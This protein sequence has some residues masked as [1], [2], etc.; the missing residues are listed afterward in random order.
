MELTHS[1][2]SDVDEVASFVAVFAKRSQDKSK[3]SQDDEKYILESNFTKNKNHLFFVLLLKGIVLYF[4]KYTYSLVVSC[5]P[6]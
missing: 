4:G 6:C 5:W 1:Y 3:F 2:G